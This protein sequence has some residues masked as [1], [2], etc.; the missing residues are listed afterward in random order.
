[1]L[2]YDARSCKVKLRAVWQVTQGRSRRVKGSCGWI[3]LACAGRSLTGWQL[4]QRGCVS[5]LAASVNIA[6]ERWAGS[7]IDE[8]ADGGCRVVLGACAEPDAGGITMAK[9]NTLKV[10]R[11]AEMCRAASFIDDNLSPLEKLHT[12]VGTRLDLDW[13]ESFAERSA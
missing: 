10:K 8:N 7:A 9:T 11:I 1:M 2:W 5:T 4:R 12:A 3:S 6:R 13:S